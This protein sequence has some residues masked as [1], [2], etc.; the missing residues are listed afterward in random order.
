MK[1]SIESKIFKN[2]KELRKKLCK[3]SGTLS[4]DWNKH[5]YDDSPMFGP[6]VLMPLAQKF[7][8]PIKE[9]KKIIADQRK[10]AKLAESAK[11]SK[12]H[13]L[14]WEKKDRQDKYQRD[15]RNYMQQQEELQAKKNRK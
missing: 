13:N 12:I 9:I 7:K 4:S 6:L 11:Q 10:L 15:F 1:N 14:H 5:F 3:I 8:M 2:Y